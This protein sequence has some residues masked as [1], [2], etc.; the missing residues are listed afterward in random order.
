METI[1]YILL[2]VVLAFFGIGMLGVAG[3]VPSLADVFIAFV[4]MT[5]LFYAICRLIRWSINDY[6]DRHLFDEYANDPPFRLTDSFSLAITLNDLMFHIMD[7][8]HATQ[9]KVRVVRNDDSV[10]DQFC[11]ELVYRK[12]VTRLR[13][14]WTT[15]E[16]ATI[17]AEQI[18]SVRDGVIKRQI[19]QK[20][21][22]KGPTGTV[23]KLM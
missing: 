22:P 5:V 1:V 14:R 8:K 7:T 15:Q 11:I 2:S 16:D 9:L 21:S 18:A 20:L 17:V 6:V 10:S 3:L 19:E 23:V 13:A 12:R 4:L